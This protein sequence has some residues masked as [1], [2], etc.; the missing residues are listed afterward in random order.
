MNT[1]SHGRRLW[2]GGVLTDEALNGSRTEQASLLPKLLSLETSNMGNNWQP[3]TSNW[4]LAT[5]N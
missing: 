4:Q 5:G 2:K 1:D 3:T